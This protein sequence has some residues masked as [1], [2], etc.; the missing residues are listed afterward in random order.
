M[1]FRLQKHKDNP[2]LKP[3]AE[4]FWENLCVLNPAVIY[5]EENSQFV[6]LYRAAGNDE[7]HRITL[8]R[9][10]SEDGIHFTRNFT[11]P[12]VEPTVNG[13]D[14]GGCEDPRLIFMNGYFY[15]TYASR[16]FL[17]GQ[18]W[19]EDRKEFGFTTPDGPY[20]LNEN[21]SVTHLAVSRN[22]MDFK[23]LGRITDARCD[24]R[25][26]VLM[27]EKINGKYVMFH[28]PMEMCGEGYPCQV[29]S[30]WISYSDD[31]IEWD[32][33][34]L[35]ATAEQPW[36]SKKIGASCPPIKTDAGWLFLY[37]GVSNEDSAYRVGAFL[38]D[39]ENPEKILARTTDFIMEPE[40]EYETSGYYNGCVFPCGNV[41]R[42]GKLYVY[43]GA[44]DKFVCVAT[45]QLT[46]LLDYLKS[47]ADKQA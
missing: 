37:H 20:F 1:M 17:P 10:T 25:D 11:K 38:L 15:L 12:V 23:K 3:N 39:L 2:I 33:G 28:R 44:A 47:G 32:N 22:L 19:R 29:P 46:E 4:N 6:M 9:A 18:Y 43:Y 16:T 24:N 41:V 42:D 21:A 45:C 14:E 26:A 35:F 36:E 8:G 31:L 40:F 34:K 7:E 13:A 27:P 30:I 5:D